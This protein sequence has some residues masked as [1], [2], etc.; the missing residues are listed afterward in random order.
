MWL[1]APSGLLLPPATAYRLPFC[2]ADTTR[3]CLCCFVCPLFVDLYTCVSACRSQGKCFKFADAL[4]GPTPTAAYHSPRA[5]MPNDCNPS[6]HMIVLMAVPLVA[7]PL[8]PTNASAGAEPP[9][10]PLNDQPMEDDLTSSMR[11]VR[12]LEETTSSPPG[13]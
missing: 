2:G 7:F 3:S 11:H 6:D 8:N 1:A 12:W 4:V 10:A 13:L 9:Q 5:L